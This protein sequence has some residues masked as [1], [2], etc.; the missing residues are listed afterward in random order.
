M[1]RVE[2]VMPPGHAGNEPPFEVTLMS[3]PPEPPQPTW[4]EQV[5]ALFEDG[6][7]AGMLLPVPARDGA[8]PLMVGVLLDEAGTV[9]EIRAGNLLPVDYKAE[10]W[11]EYALRS[12]FEGRPGQPHIYG[13]ENR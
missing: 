2:P 3:Q 13:Y 6:P 4:P 9:S 5:E 1:V 10:G 7:V 12:A 8:P 11:L